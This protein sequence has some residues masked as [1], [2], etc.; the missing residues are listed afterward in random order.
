M[1]RWRR[2]FC[3]RERQKVLVNIEQ[4]A[5]VMRGAAN[6]VDYFRD[7]EGRYLDQGLGPRWLCHGCETGKAD[8]RD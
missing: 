2:K 4:G 3:F 8:F 1:L 6:I 7:F 5:L